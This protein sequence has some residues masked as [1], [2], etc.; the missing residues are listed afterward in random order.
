MA[1]LMHICGDVQTCALLEQNIL[2]TVDKDMV[3]LLCVCTD[4]EICCI[5]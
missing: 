4:A 2:H 3:S 1:S 5:S